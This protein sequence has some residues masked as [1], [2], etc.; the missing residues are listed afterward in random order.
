MLFPRRFNEVALNQ[1]AIDIELPSV[2]SGIYYLKKVFQES[3]IEVEFNI[4]ECPH[5][6]I[7]MPTHGHPHTQ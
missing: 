2:P 7:T 6:H 5:I 4:Y 3:G 1:H